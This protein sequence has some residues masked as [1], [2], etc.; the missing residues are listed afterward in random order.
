M[1][2]VD[3]TLFQRLADATCA[4]V[5]SSP[6]SGTVENRIAVEAARDG[7]LAGLKVAAMFAHKAMELPDCEQLGPVDWETGQRECALERRGDCICNVQSETAELLR[8]TLRRELPD[9]C[10][11]CGKAPIV[12]E[13]DGDQ[14]CQS[15]ASKWVQGE[16]QS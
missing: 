12:T 4:V 2:K 3:P 6:A 9:F 1:S 7:Y 13:L 5:L 15:C 16:G 11:Q 14:L 10:D 8:D